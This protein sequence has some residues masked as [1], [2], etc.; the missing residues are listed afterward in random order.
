MPCP[1]QALVLRSSQS[2]RLGPVARLMAALRAAH[3]TTCKPAGCRRVSAHT[4]AQ[5][6]GF[7]DPIIELLYLGGVPGQSAGV[8]PCLRRELTSFPERSL[9]QQGD[10]DA[11]ARPQDDHDHGCLSGLA[12]QRTNDNGCRSAVRVHV[13]NVRLWAR[14]AVFLY[15]SWHMNLIAWKLRC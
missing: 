9:R 15:Y 5:D 4:C 1:Q 8:C 14:A 3:E 6:V 2:G 13:I 10:E 11:K 12:D 7:M